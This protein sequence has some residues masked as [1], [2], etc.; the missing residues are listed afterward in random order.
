MNLHIYLYMHNYIHVLCII[1]IYIY[2]Y[3]HTYIEGAEPRAMRF[4]MSFRVP[5]F[6][7]MS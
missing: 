4:A 1:Y 3:I 2:T 6:C 7:V 5:G